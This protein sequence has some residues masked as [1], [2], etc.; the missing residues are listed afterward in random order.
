[1]RFRRRRRASERSTS[2][3]LTSAFNEL[4][5]HMRRSGIGKPPT[6]GERAFLSDFPQQMRRLAIDEG[7]EPEL[8]DAVEGVARTADWLSDPPEP[9]API[10]DIAGGGV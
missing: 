9:P 5:V 3:H 4:R 8:R 10:V 2:D 1:M 6:P 7:L